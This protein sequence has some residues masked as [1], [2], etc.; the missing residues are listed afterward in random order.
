MG[1]LSHYV[2]NSAETSMEFLRF[3]MHESNRSH[4]INVMVARLVFV[5]FIF[6]FMLFA[7]DNWSNIPVI[8]GENTLDTVVAFHDSPEFSETEWERSIPYLP[9]GYTGYAIEIIASDHLLKSSHS[10]LSDFGRIF[11]V[12]S[13]NKYHY[14]FLV[15]YHR[16]KSVKQFYRKI[17]KSKAPNSKVV[18]Y[19]NGVK[20]TDFSW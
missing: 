6:P 18:Q 19:L 16:R 12:Q 20:T 11:M 15:D 2:N 8:G 9:S 3:F 7:Q 1:N 17:V 4:R 5:F 13:G 10:A 14:L